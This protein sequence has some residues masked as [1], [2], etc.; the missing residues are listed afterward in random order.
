MLSHRDDKRKLADSTGRV[1]K[2]WSMASKYTVAEGVLKGTNRKATI[3]VR[4]VPSS[5]NDQTVVEVIP[6]PDQKGRFTIVVENEF[7]QR[8]ETFPNLSLN[9]TDA[10]DFMKV[11]N[12]PDPRPVAPA[13]DNVTDGSCLIR[14][15]PVGR[16][17]GVA[18]AAQRI[19]LR[20]LPLSYAG[21]VGIIYS[22]LLRFA[23]L[24]KADARLQEKFGAAAERFVA[25]AEES[26]ADFAAEFR[27]GP[28]PDEGYYLTCERGGAF[29]YDN[30]GEPFNYLGA[31][32][33]SELALFRLTG[34]PVYREQAERMIRLFKRRLRPAPDD[35]YVWYYWYE[36]ITTTGWTR[37]NGPSGN[38]PSLEPAPYVEDVSHAQ[39][40]LR[41][42]VDAAAAG[43]EFDRADLVRFANTFL[44][45]VVRADRRGFNARVDGSG[46]GAAY[47]NA[48]VAGWLPLAA[49]DRQVFDTCRQVYLN[50]GKDDLYGLARLLK[51][52]KRLGS[53]GTTTTQAAVQP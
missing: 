11:I 24:V 15:E 12:T 38:Y 16:G 52:E 42:V 27:Q 18:P 23:E 47:E 30:V 21:Y 33:E 31:H 17:R 3:R 37:A 14:V 6:A 22:P 8:K 9:A 4:S 1:R 7:H 40:D 39:L 10:R 34:K 29:P 49:T 35:A 13:G 2:G 36:P 43:I 19:R 25:A 50:R 32:V 45:H 26:Y 28:A 5:A 20:P 48:T 53:R 41:L 51:W 44:H 46:G